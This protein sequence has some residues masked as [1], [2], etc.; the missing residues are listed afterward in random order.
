MCEVVPGDIVNLYPGDIIPADLESFPAKIPFFENRLSAFLV[1]MFVLIVAVAF[2]ITLS[3]FG[4]LFGSIPP[5]GIYG[6]TLFLIILGYL[7]I[8]QKIKS[9][10]IKKDE[11]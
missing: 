10:Y 8:T 7:A 5:T 4:K 1:G 3:S 6:F 11:Y 2:V 9:W